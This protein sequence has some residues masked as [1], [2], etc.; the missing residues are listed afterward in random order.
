M[1]LCVCALDDDEGVLYTLKAMAQ[2]QE[3]DFR[4]TTS[5]EECIQ[6]VRD[7]IVEILLLDYH[8]P[9]QNGLDVLRRVMEISD[10]VPVLMLTVE[11][12]TEVAEALLL[13]G[14]QDFI[15]K[16]IRLADFLSRIRLHEQLLLRR[17][18]LSGQSRKGIGAHTLQKVVECLKKGGSF[19]IDEVA[20]EC[21]LSYTTAHRYLD[22]LVK[23]RLAHATPLTGE[24]KQGRPAKSYRF[25]GVTQPTKR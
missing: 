7:G 4:G 21:A 11:Q 16:P 6:W 12:D 25:S 14:A 24:G 1:S 18:E 23:R 5:V 9:R 10:E 2:T 3:W 20:R 15:N 17:Q 19:E 13:A 8:M 22:Y